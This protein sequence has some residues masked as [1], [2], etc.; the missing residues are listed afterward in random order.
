MAANKTKPR[1]PNNPSKP[2]PEKTIEE[3][4]QKRTQHHHIL[5]RPDT[6]IGSVV[7]SKQSLW[8]FEGGKMV[9][10]DIAYVPGL[11][12][13]FDEILV[14]AADNCQRDP[15]MDRLEVEIDAGANFISVFNNGEGI[16]VAIHGSENVYVA[17]MI[18]GQLLTS[19][20]Y[21]D[22]CKKTTGGRN[23]FG[24]KLTNIFSTE[25]VVESAD[26][27]RRKMYKQ[28]FS[29]NMNK[30][31][32]PVITNYNGESW[33]RVSF[34]P[35]LAKFQMDHLEADVLAL[36]KRR[37]VDVAGCIGET[38]NVVLNGEQ[39]PVSS[40]ADYV[41]L[42]LEARFGDKKDS[43]PRFVER[44]NDRWEIC[45]CVRDSHFEQVSFVNA[46]ATMK[47]G[48]H[49][50]Y[51]IDQLIDYVYE[52]IDQ[53]SPNIFLRP[54]LV[55]SNLWV[56]VNALIDNPSF[57]SQTKLTLTTK[58][59]DFGSTCVL[60][61]D[62]LEEVCK[63]GVVD[64]IMSWVKYKQKREEKRAEKE[65]RQ[66]ITGI[67]KLEDANEAGSE[68]AR[69]CTLILTEGDSAKALAMAGI[70]AVG[71]DCYG[72][73][74][75]RGK[76][77]N[78]REANDFQ[79]NG[80]EEIQSIMKILHLEYNKQ[81]NSVEDLRY[82]H[83]MIMTD[84]D[85]DGSHIKGLLINLFHSLWP[86][87]LKIPS[88]LLGFIT[89]IIKATRGG[90]ILSFYSIPEYESWKQGLGGNT[91]GWSIKYYKGLG[92]STSKEGKE[93]FQALEK[94]KKDFLWLDEEDNDAI[95]LAFSKDKIQ[96]RK[97]WLQKYEPG[98]FLD[99]KEKHVKYSDFVNKELIQF[100][101]ADLKRSIPCMVDGLKPGQRKILFSCFKRN[102]IQEAKVAQ[103]SGYVSEHT[104]YHHGE[105][106]LAKT[107][108]GMAQ[109]YVGSNNINLLQ[110]NGQFGTRH[111][112]GKDHASARYIYTCLSP[113]TRFLFHI[114]DDALL[115]Y[116][117][118]DGQSVEPAWYVP[119]IPMVL[120]N[121]SEG[122]GTGWSTYVPNYNP[123]DIIAN[124]R[125]FLNDEPMEP[126]MPWYKGFKGTI[127][128]INAKEAGESYAVK[129]IIQEVNKTTVRITELPVRKSTEDYKQFLDTLLSKGGRNKEQFIKDFREFN[130]DKTVHFEIY[131]TEKN[132]AIAK[133]EGLIE[134][135]KL[136]TTISTS[137]MHL[138][139]SNGALVKYSSPEKI[140]EEFCGLRREFYEKRKGFM[141][142]MLERELLKLE[143]KVRF[144]NAVV[145][146]KIIIMNR[147]RKDLLAE[148]KQKKFA[149]FPSNN[150]TTGSSNPTEN[151]YGYLLSMP[152]G[153][154]TSEN[155][156]QLCAQRKRLKDEV[157]G[158]R[159]A[160]PKSLW[161]KDLDALEQ[162]LNLQSNIYDRP[163]NTRSEVNA[164]ISK[165]PKRTMKKKKKGSSEKHAN[166]KDALAEIHI[167]PSND[168]GR[169]LQAVEPQCMQRKDDVA[170]MTNPPPVHE[171]EGKGLEQNQ[172]QAK[173]NLSPEKSTGKAPG[174]MD[175]RGIQEE[176][177]EAPKP[178]PPSL[179]LDETRGL[180]QR[181][182]MADPTSLPDK[183]RD[184][185]LPEGIEAKKA[186]PSI[187]E[188]S[189][190]DEE[191][192]DTRIV[193]PDCKKA[194]KPS[195]RKTSKDAQNKHHA[196]IT[197]KRGKT[198]RENGGTPLA[199]DTSRVVLKAI[200]NNP[201]LSPEKKLRKTNERPFRKKK[202]SHFDAKGEKENC[203]SR[204][205]SN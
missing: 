11:Y 69:E 86:S 133:D 25:F 20:N 84:Q 83:V 3:T 54:H 156:Q 7:K 174:A 8:V 177:D 183:S 135:F 102:F 65:K 168:T 107:I 87:L 179:E 147:K 148:L 43:I 121:G 50:D 58:F 196:M 178:N 194:R 190:T 188:I 106:S 28:V 48:T 59:E 159:H 73:F 63:A 97:E 153:T 6:Y 21:D 101:A 32:P 2:E 191:K 81:Y 76:P 33:T 123:R 53:T 18:F 75:L 199:N 89:P 57:N 60:H 142:S 115:H 44:F 110:P 29:D 80:N 201:V 122:I 74:P 36:M 200:E 180:E 70:S 126:M 109:D 82:G 138:F 98:T 139:N 66:R 12:K 100:S 187:I 195:A 91:S 47:G 37:V 24:A 79:I 103:F 131:M 77:L 198:N 202:S 132:L 27:K 163:E 140:I 113:I 34:K 137:N 176:K 193:A 17:E 108:V 56:F 129:G 88:F 42:Y 192:A 144:V 14:N 4:Y 141:L 161:L 10:R 13:I 40:F 119:I 146:G 72:V 170:P 145:D 61:D 166:D 164:E 64:N 184:M 154:L 9:N 62:Y 85:H 96:A 117:S 167:I 169:T 23:G 90:Q 95:E 112:G 78:V 175:S 152:I 51:V 158:L 52:K 127:E 49:V 124:V 105:A 99:Q 26:A 149:P 5:L 120:V 157:D 197:R 165:R 111:Q 128:R 125:H 68:R 15:S 116:L 114:N 45:V 38:V 186:D 203:P 104:V 1:G 71:R 205:N 134:K 130:D 94:H 19:S 150:N 55:K 92:T 143:N 41:D 189:D 39:V 151:E 118:E 185:M 46:I 136:S 173:Q 162:K 171:D 16:P 181:G 155:V 182:R 93:Y 160:T 31:S 172:D 30:V 67:T 22:S 204:G 35:D